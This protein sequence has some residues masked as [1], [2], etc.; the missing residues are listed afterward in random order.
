MTTAIFNFAE[1]STLCVGDWVEV[2]TKDEILATLDSAGCLEGMPFMPEMFAFCGQR[3]KVY[4]RAHKTCDTAFPVQG[5]RVAHAVHL[6]TRCDGSAHGGCQ[7]GCLIFWKDAWLKPVNRRSPDSSL[8][9]ADSNASQTQQDSFCTESIVSAC[10]TKNDGTG[11]AYACQATQLHYASAPLPWWDVRQYIEDYRSGNVSL[12]RIVCGA[13][14][15]LTYWLSRAG[16]GLGRP[17]RWFY[18]KFYPLWHGSPFPRR[19]GAIPEGTST[20]AQTLNLQPGDLVRIKSHADIVKTLSTNN[21]NRGLYFDAEEVPYCGGTY[22]VLRRIS[23]IIN[24]RTGRMLEMK[25]PCVVLDSVICQSRYSECRLFCPRSIYAYWR[26]IWLERVEPPVPTSG[27]RAPAADT[28][29][30]EPA[31]M[32]R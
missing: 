6:D 20:P 18:D 32:G 28:S 5:R 19:H 12:W 11:Q 29:P 24:E 3:F 13:V 8:T 10:S 31:S 21:R 2:R 17:T 7:A 25:T 23:R 22:R 16:I 4:K 30:F 14:Y 15:F 27:L 9:S 1:S 26:E